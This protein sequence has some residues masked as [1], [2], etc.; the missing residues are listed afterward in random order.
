MYRL[1]VSEYTTDMF[2]FSDES[3]YNRNT[4][5][6]SRG[7]S[8]CGR[9]ATKSSFFIRG[10]K[11]TIEA[12]LCVVGYLS[13]RIQTGAMNSEQYYN[14]VEQD[15][16]SSSSFSTYLYITNDTDIISDSSHESLSWPPKHFDS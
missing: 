4:L 10:Q 15:L 6:R 16:V 3:G 8:L 11:Y 7:W 5:A 12:A 2:V 14:W 1:Q 9:R 13:Y